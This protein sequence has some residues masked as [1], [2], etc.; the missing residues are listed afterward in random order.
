M[1]NAN[2]VQV[3][4][5]GG[6]SISVP[7][8]EGMN[9]QQA[10]EGAYGQLND[11]GQ[12]TYA[13]QY[14]GAGL[15]YLVMMINETYDSFTSSAAPFFYWEFLLNGSP[16]SSGIDSVTLTPGDAVGFSFEMYEAARHD[17]ST[18]KVKH[19]LQVAHAPA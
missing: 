18:L 4:V 8:F 17:A 19:A 3:T 5:A 1:S 16:S 15:G 12:F 10:I 2:T 14:Y 9:A 11:S 6:P 7:W 13:I